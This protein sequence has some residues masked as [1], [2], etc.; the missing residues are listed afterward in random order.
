MELPLV[1]GA[2]STCTAWLFPGGRE[3]VFITPLRL[4]PDP[5]TAAWEIVTAVMPEFVRVN[6]CRLFAPIGTFPK[7]R[8]VVL[9]ARVP[10]AVL[11]EPVFDGVPA[12]V[13]PTQPETDKIAMKRVAIMANVAIELCC[14]GSSVAACCF[15]AG[16]SSWE[17][18]VC[19][20]MSQPV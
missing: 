19:D 17:A 11:L 16:F 18:S 5:E 1:F 14:L 20:F 2:N 8:A 6:V 15:D 4:N 13:S 10:G 9:G 7:L 3:I 12:L